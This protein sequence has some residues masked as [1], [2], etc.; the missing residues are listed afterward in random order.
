[1]QCIRDMPLILQFSQSKVYDDR[2][3]VCRGGKPRVMTLI[4]CTQVPNAVRE[5]SAQ[6]CACG[7]MY[8]SRS[9]QVCLVMLIAAS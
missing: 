2:D 4:M 7:A 3:G 1:M 5:A 8:A 9:V 6:S